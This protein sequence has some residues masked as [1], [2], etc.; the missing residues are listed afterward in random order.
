MTVIFHGDNTSQ[1][2]SFVNSKGFLNTRS[3]NYT[4]TVF[5]VEND[6]C[7]EFSLSF[8]CVVE[9]CDFLS[10]R[11]GSIKKLAST[12]LRHNLHK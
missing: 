10:V 5:A 8:K 11:F 2:Q 6:F 4:V 9:F 1:V 3:F 7:F 12:T